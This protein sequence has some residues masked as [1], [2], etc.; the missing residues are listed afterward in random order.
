MTGGP[1]DRVKVHRNPLRMVSSPSP[2]VAT[3]YLASY[4]VV[5]TALFA[6]CCTVLVVCGVLSLFTLGVPLLAGAALVVR[7]GAQVE[8]LRGRLV[9]ARLGAT[10]RAVDRPGVLAQVRTRWTDPA[11]FR[12]VGYVVLLYLPLLV[13]D[14][15][16]LVVWLGLLAGVTLPAWYWSVT[17]R[18][19]DGT[20]DHGV[21]IGFLRDG[22]HG[23]GTFGVWVGSLPAA[24]VVAMVFAVLS[25]LGAYL[26]VAA[27]RLHTTIAGRLLGPYRDPLDPARRILATPGP[28]ST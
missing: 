18:W 3:A 20:R 26:A 9:G 19:S 23:T 5:G 25:P 11:T 12:D 10:Y 7:G 14:V 8:R 13:L 16:A 28:L 2:W 1:V 4:V 17:S 15:V 24:L 21:K 27:T 22:P 6:V